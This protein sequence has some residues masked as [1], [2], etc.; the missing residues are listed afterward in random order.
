MR[1]MDSG[2]QKRVTK[3][4]WDI[5]PMP[6]QA[7]TVDFHDVYTQEEWARIKMGLEPEDMNEK[8]FVY[9][10]DNTL[11]LHRSWTG[12]CIYQVGFEETDEGWRAD[13]AVVNA[14]P[15]Q[16]G[17]VDGQYE[18]RLL[19]YLIGVLLLGKDLEFPMPDDVPPGASPDIV[20]HVV[21]GNPPDAGQAD[22]CDP[23]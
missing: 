20:R 2:D 7:A 9:L 14:D 18:P 21:A 8:W 23:D 10:E 19:R 3:D 15:D 4:C 17:E 12:H 13:A 6:S 11:Y 1:S 22:T 16:H 5:Q